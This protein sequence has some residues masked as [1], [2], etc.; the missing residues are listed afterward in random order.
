MSCVYLVYRTIT[1]GY[2]AF[3]SLQKF[4]TSIEDGF[5]AG[6]IANGCVTNRSLGLAFVS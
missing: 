4:T 5:G 6:V 1:L 2:K 3:H